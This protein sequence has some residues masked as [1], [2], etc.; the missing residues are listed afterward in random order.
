[1]L[2]NSEISWRHNC[3]NRYH[4]LAAFMM[5]GAFIVILFFVVRLS[6]AA[7]EPNSLKTKLVVKEGAG[8]GFEQVSALAAGIDFTNTLGELKGASNR[9][10]FNGAGVA[11]G[12]VDGNGHP[13]LFFCGLD[14]PNQLYL[15][16]GNWKFSPSSIPD[17]MALPGF[18]TRGAV[19]ADLN[20]DQ[21]LDLVMTTVGGGLR[22]FINDGKGRFL[23]NT[24]EAGLEGHSGGSTIALADIDGNGSI[25]LYVAN[26]RS[27][28][29]R[30]RGR[31][32]MRQVNG[33]IIPPD[34]LK[35][36]L[37]I[38][39]GQIHE[40][41]EPD[42][43]YINDGSGKF[44]R[45]SWTDGRFRSSGKTLSETPRDWGL[46]ATFRDI[47]GDHSPDIYV[48]NDYWTPDRIWINDG[49]G[50]FDEL[51]VELLKTTS[52]SSMGVDFADVDL[53]GD[54]DAFIVDML[55]RDL[56]V[57]KRQQPAFNPLF[58]ES[59]LSGN[60][61]QVMHNTLLLQKSDGSFAEI[62]YFAGV[63]ASD[64][65]WS[66]VFMD[67]DLDGYADLLISAGYPHDVQDLDAIQLIQSKQ[68]SWD[69]FKDPAALREAFAKELMEHYRLY[70]D[71]DL[72]V[73]AY[74]NSGNGK[75]EDFTAVWGTDISGIHQGFA[76][77]DLD[78]DG[79]LDLIL[80]SLNA[81]PLLLKNN[82]SRPRIKLRL[83]G[84]S[85]NTQAI[86]AKV[87]LKQ[88]NGPDLSSEVFAGGRYLSGSDTEIV[89]A[90]G[91][92][93]QDLAI[94]IHWPLGGFSRMGNIQPNHSYVVE[95]PEKNTTISKRS[96]EAIETMT[97]L[98]EDISE[99]L[100]LTFNEADSND[101]LRQPLLPF[102]LSHRGP[103][104]AIGDL[105][106]DGW[107]DIW[108]GTGRG[109]QLRT[110]FGNGEG[111]PRL[112]KWPVPLP[113]DSMGL[114]MG[115]LIGKPELNLIG[116]AGY[117]Q[118]VP[119]GLV[120]GKNDGLDWKSVDASIPGAGPMALGPLNGRGE[121]SLFLAGGIKPG[122]YPA[123][124]PSTLMGLRNG[125]FT[126]DKRN[127]TLMGGLSMVKGVVWSDL[128]NDGFPELIV[129]TEW[130]PVR[131]F[132]NRSGS[133]F[134]VTEPWGLAGFKGLW[135]GI[136][137]ADL[138]GNGYPDIIAGNWGLNSSW[139]ATNS[140]PF[141]LFHGTFSNPAV[142][143]LIETQY[144]FDL[145]MTPSRMLDE[146][147]LSLPFIYQ[148]I[149]HYR[150]Y[151]EASL[152]KLTGKR[153]PLGRISEATTFASMVFFNEGPGRVF[154]A[155]ELPAEAQWAPVYGVQ[156]ADFNGDGF[157]DLILCQNQ[158]RTRPGWPRQDNGGALLLQGDGKGGLRVLSSME[159]GLLVSGD[160][161]SAALGDINKDGRTD[162]GLTLNKGPLKI[163][164]NQSS[165]AG[166]RVR[167]HGPAHNP[168][169]VG[170]QLRLHGENNVWGP[171]REIQAG[172]GWFSQ[173]SPVTV[174]H[175]SFKATGIWVRWPG[176][177]ETH[178]P[179]DQ[180]KE[181]TLSWKP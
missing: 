113:D 10:L 75:F 4:W 105:N 39:S 68:H 2:Q 164:L 52:A 108:I 58:M 178:A 31:V 65:S 102:Q 71:L 168:A 91:E 53:D 126:T 169:G 92:K 161:R 157:E 176:G 57:R 34:E 134:D 93:Q 138:D 42:N 78:G 26:N 97:V 48:C 54:L 90:A 47:N 151:S 19:L 13:D 129:G 89:F 30:D 124:H 156:A 174:L 11:A 77:A 86:G 103:G 145:E 82:A 142:T 87:F 16:S 96:S 1:M 9:V 135:N 49:S 177:A 112:K 166:L 159:S 130:G 66:P 61:Q 25:D 5:N 41:G 63:E 70:P 56:Q 15:N 172:N 167:L 95:E 60:R 6:A 46:T 44:S 152:Q 107:D 50:S 104:I 18:P 59:S 146:L 153:F 100:A 117:E 170:C 162:L 128:N 175:S 84:Q 115:Y 45:V 144:R 150:D 173:N 37:L 29:I 99:D 125:L 69:R 38:H 180:K 8:V 110:F 83:R 122:H 158:S 101:F 35:D 181:I 137:T 7:A 80:N 88:E 98:F 76:T 17:S 64:W 62:A 51:S 109:G 147:G 171:V 85:S 55:S 121:L 73:V 111:S 40:Y 79:D 120:T 140:H 67:V 114:L 179:L 118:V 43:L 33:R 155:K 141:R 24:V 131:V 160:L 20:G 148:N 3:F 139:R 81:T 74:R 94:E 133:L 23:E 136:A 36:R 14:T 72:P 127:N 149:R 154:R 27:D 143:D 106:Q 28:D 132:E 119:S 22:L 165:N 116:L 32:N 21:S 12:D 163:Y 123:V